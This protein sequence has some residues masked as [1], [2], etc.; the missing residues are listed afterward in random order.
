MDSINEFSD[1]LRDWIHHLFPGSKDD[2]PRNHVMLNCPLCIKEGRPDIH[3]HM[4]INVGKNGKALYFKCFRNS[5]HQGILTPE[6][7]ALLADDRAYLIDDNLIEALNKYNKHHQ[8]LSRYK[9]NLLNQ[10][11]INLPNIN[12]NEINQYKLK[13]IN[14]RLGTCLDFREIKLDKIVFK[15]TDL[16][17]YNNINQYSRSQG[18]MNLID[19]YFIGFLTN[20]NASVILRNIAYGKIDLPEVINYRYI[21]YPIIEGA[22]SGYYIISSSNNIYNTIK[23]HIAE[24]TFDT[25][26]VFY[27]LREANRIDN[28]Y[29]SIGG[30]SYLNCIKYFLVNIGLIKVEFHIYID[31][32]I[33]SFVIPQI[34]SFLH[35]LN[36]P[37][38]IHFNGSGEKDF[39]VIKEKIKECIIKV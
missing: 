6:N 29:C 15:L 22:D 18:I 1:Y 4:G 9:I 8:L 14:R 2:G 17:K 3:Y 36:I 37:A 5:N 23:V 32:D 30:N 25:L 33:R 12:Q 38:Y 11:N 16:L 10:Y 35:P 20:N 34:K 27:N 19:L 21:K 7:L 31:N 24:G 28:I 13:Y 39:G 26:S